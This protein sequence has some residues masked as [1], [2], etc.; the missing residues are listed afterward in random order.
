MKITL[1]QLAEQLRR[2][3]A[4]VYCVSGEE[5]LLVA[6]A[7]D[8]IRA[9]ARRAGFLQREVFFAEKSYDW[10]AARASAASM[11]L[12]GDRRLIELRFDS[13]SPG[14]DAAG[15]LLELVG[16]G[17]PDV[18]LLV[19][20]GRLER[21]ALD[22]EWL[23]AVQ[24][25]G[26]WLPVWPVDAPRLQAWLDARCRAQG[27]A[28]SA[29]ALSLLAERVEGNLLA[30]Q[31]EIDKLRLLVAG[32][33]LDAEQILLAVS[34]SAR[35]DISDLGEAAAGGDTLRALRILEALRGEGVEPV[36]IWWAL[37]RELHALWRLR[38]HGVAAEG[39]GPRRGPQYLRAL[40]GARRRVGGLP[41]LRLTERAHRADRA[42]KGRSDDAPWDALMAYCAELAGTRVLAIPA[43][44]RIGARA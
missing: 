35:F 16:S 36:L 6:E 19:L 17:G 1:E 3:L 4:E 44:P 42:I 13:G 41:F 25:R 7:A 29:E 21:T 38:L 26:V 11:S 14:K 18:C 39:K 32:A 28:P 20:A 27:L 24:S 34:D 8:A 5:P 15:P 40:E 23:E 43:A 37:T 30:A 12:F 2:G 10:S 22:S 33:D 9:A 31:Q